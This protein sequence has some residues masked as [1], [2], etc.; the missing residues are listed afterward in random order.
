M[1]PMTERTTSAVKTLPTGWIPIAELRLGKKIRHTLT[2]EENF[3]GPMTK[4]ST[5]PKGAH[6]RP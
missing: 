2:L 3:V 1:V 5:G 6:L 4:L